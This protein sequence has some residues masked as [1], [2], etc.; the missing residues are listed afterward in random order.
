MKPT[1]TIRDAAILVALVLLATS[2]RVTALPEL[3]LAG[4]ETQ[5]AEP[6][7]VAPVA[8]PRVLPSVDDT[9]TDTEVVPPC[10]QR[11]KLTVRDGE[12]ELVT[13]ELDIDPRLQAALGLCDV[14]DDDPAADPTEKA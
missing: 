7:A 2:V 12:G 14:A 6:V 10:R 1:Q 4:S 8:E 5:A 9:D 11:Q 13:I 3:P